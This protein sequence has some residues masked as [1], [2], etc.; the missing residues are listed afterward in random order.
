[1]KTKHLLQS[2]Y[3]VL[4]SIVLLPTGWSAV[5]LDVHKN[6]VK[7]KTDKKGIEG[8]AGC[9]KKKIKLKSAYIYDL[10]VE[11]NSTN[12]D[13]KICTKNGRYKHINRISSTS[14]GLI[15]FKNLRKG[16]YK[17]VAY[18]AT[19]TG[20]DLSTVVD[21]KTLDN[22]PTQSIIY[23]KEESE[24]FT[25]TTPLVANADV[26]A[27][28]LK[29]FEIFPNPASDKVYVQLQGIQL[30]EEAEIYVQS[31][32]GR[33]AKKYPL[34]INENLSSIEIDVSNYPSGTYL[35]YLSD[36]NG[37]QYKEKMVVL[38]F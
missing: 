37:I 6:S 7:T 10:F 23:Q 16:N 12:I 27:N 11:L 13:E 3:L 14:N 31:L 1:M 2:L 15:E 33:Q 20:C 9:Q 35:I 32:A 22:Y 8:Y 4:F 29:Q 26:S 21:S 24:V 34:H 18:Y 19:P 28:E 36:K 38:N 5:K 17:I 30:N 25:I